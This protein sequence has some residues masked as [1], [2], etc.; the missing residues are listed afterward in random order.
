MIGHVSAGRVG[1]DERAAL[2]YA[3][4]RSEL[5]SNLW[6]AALGTA[7]DR[8]DRPGEARETDLGLDGLLTLLTDGKQGM[9]PA[10]P[11]AAMPDPSSRL[12]ADGDS[13][14]GGS[15]RGE[16]GGHVDG[17]GP[18]QIYRPTLDA[19]AARTGIPSSALAAIVHAE[20]ATGPDGR[21]LAYS[22]NPRS[23]AAGLGQFLS[24]TWISETER[25]GTWL[26]RL[27]EQRGW[28]DGRGRVQSG[29]RSELLALRYDGDASIQAIADYAQGNLAQLRASGVVI[30][31]GA[32][33]IAQSAYVGHHLGMG[34][35]VRFLRGE[36]DSGRA[37]KLLAAQIGTEAAEQRIAEAGS[38][39]RAHRDWLLGYIAHNVQAA[40]FEGAPPVAA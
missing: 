2:I 26:H 27:A 22:R 24:G 6:R 23:S 35:A 34:D 36:L 25:A 13:S 15:G 5:A 30:G 17:L 1:A 14:S 37:H 29:A 12:D 38:A 11:T 18:N 31:P 20:A 21:W 40:R 16:E 8:N 4:A 9:P 7:D 19:A 39:T 32:E 10:S 28:L 3:Q 33:S